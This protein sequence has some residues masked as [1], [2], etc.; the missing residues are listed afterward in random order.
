MPK[1]TQ[2]CDDTSV[3]QSETEIQAV[4]TELSVKFWCVPITHHLLLTI[5][6]D[7]F[8]VSHVRIS[9]PRD[10]GLSHQER[11]GDERLG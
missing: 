5:N 1:A 7:L 10:S 4:K 11:I 2:A 9:R 3:W 6:V 8:N